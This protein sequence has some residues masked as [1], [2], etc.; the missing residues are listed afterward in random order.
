MDIFWIFLNRQKLLPALVQGTEVTV[1][2]SFEPASGTGTRDRLELP[3]MA[4]GWGV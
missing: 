4:E 3:P 2:V 1:P